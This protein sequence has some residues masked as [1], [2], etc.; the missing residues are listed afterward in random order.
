VN[1]R[2]SALEAVELD[3]VR[4][5]ERVGAVRLAAAVLLAP[6]VEVAEA[7]L[8]GVSVPA[9]RLDPDWRRRLRL[10]GDVVLDESLA[11]KVIA[12]GPPK[13]VTA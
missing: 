8:G 9:E 5:H 13:K 4:R 2:L 11:L 1:V 12:C 10:V 6:R 3:A 7:L